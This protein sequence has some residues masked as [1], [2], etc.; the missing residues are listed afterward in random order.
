VVKGYIFAFQRNDDGT[1]RWILHFR[2]RLALNDI[3]RKERNYM[4][5]PIAE[6][7]DFVILVCQGRTSAR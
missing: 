6:K 4:D 3:A 5:L 7:E 2:V 1:K